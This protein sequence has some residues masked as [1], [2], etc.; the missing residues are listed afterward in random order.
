VVPVAAEALTLVAA[1]G[2]NLA[3][4]WWPGAE[5]G[6]RSVVFLAG[7]A[8]RQDYFKPLAQFLAGKGW[9]VL[10]FDYR[11]QG[12][13]QDP[14][15]DRDVTIDD[16]VNL[17]LPAATAE[18]RRRAGAGFLGVFAHSIGGQILGQSPIR[19]EVDG[20]LFVAAQRGIP[21][22]YEG[23]GRWGVRYAY[24]VFPLL[25]GALGRLPVSRFTLPDAVSA[26]VVLQWARWGRSGVFTDWRGESVEPRF[27]D[28]DK[29]LTTI[30]VADD[31][32]YA[33]PAAV[34]A[35]TKL[36]TR[37]RARRETLL[38][39]DYG[40]PS[41]GHFGLFNPRAPRL[42]WSKAE[43]WLRELETQGREPSVVRPGAGD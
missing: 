30:A 36:Y 28:Y 35:L 9:G 15:L 1:D 5:A 4:K 8:A 21:R 6:Q 26:K 14:A 2:R 22:L 33:P 43:A 13:S 41:I 24:A 37:A 11:S 38:P 39:G 27:A 19:R 31:S 34:E 42:L 17:D 12:A 25:I 18:A 7:L 10:T 3:A 32:M 16:W 40:L 23:N 20:A 29:P